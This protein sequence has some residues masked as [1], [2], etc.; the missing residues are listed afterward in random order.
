MLCYAVLCCAML[1]CV[2][3]CCTL[4]FE[5]R[6]ESYYWLLDVLDLYK[7][8]VWEY[9]RLNVEYNV[10][11]KRRLLRLVEEG[12]VQ[13][14]DDPRL[15]TLNGLRRR[16]YSP[17]AIRDFCF[18]ES[19][20]RI[21]TNHGLLFLEEIETLLDNN[22]VVLYGCYD[23]SSKQLRYS[24]GRIVY[25]PAQRK[26]QLLVFTSRG[27]VA[28][29]VK[30]SGPYGLDDVPDDNSRGR[31]VSLRVTPDH[32]MFAQLGYYDASGKL[33]ATK[34]HGPVTADKLVVPACRCPPVR[35]G[36]LDCKHRRAAMRLLA[37]AEAGYLPRVAVRREQVRA[38]LHLDDIQFIKFI[39]LL[40]FWLGDGFMTYKGK[41]GE[42]YNSVSFSQ[43]KK[44]DLDWLKK[45]FVKVGLQPSDWRTAKVGYQTRL[46]ITQPA[47]FAYFDG[48]FGRKYK[49]SRHFVNA[50][51]AGTSNSTPPSATR[52]SSVSSVCDLTSSCSTTFTFTPR[53]RSVSA[54]STE[55][56]DHATA[57]TIDAPA[58]CCL[59]CGGVEGLCGDRLSGVWHCAVC[60][61]DF[62]DAATEP[63]G[64][65]T[66]EGM[67]VEVMDDEDQPAIKVEMDIDEPAVKDE[68]DEDVPVT[69]HVDEPDEKADGSAGAPIKKDSSG[70]AVPPALDT[71]VP[72][73]VK[74]VKWLPDWLLAELSAAEM[75]KFIR[76]LWRAD[77]AWSKQDSVIYT[78]G[79]RFRDQLQQALLHCGYTPFATIMYGK[80]N[81]RGYKY[82]DWSVDPGVYPKWWVEQL[83]ETEQLNFTPIKST[84]EGWR[85]NWT[86][87]CDAT[88]R[89]AKGSCFPPMARQESI[90][91]SSYD[92]GRDGRLWCVTI[93]HPDHLIFAQRAHRNSA[94]V[95]IKQS[96]PIVVGNCNAIGI[97]RN[98]TMIPQAT[99]EYWLRNDLETKARRAMCVVDPVRVVLTNYPADQVEQLTAPNFPKA[100]QLG[101]HTVP[102]SR[103]L[104]IDRDDV[105]LHDEK[106]FF[107]LAVGKEAHLKYAYN[108]RCDKIDVAADD[109]THITQL[110]CTVDSSNSNKPKGKLH[111]V[112][113]PSPG[114]PPLT[115]TLR[116]Y[117]NLF[118]SKVSTAHYR[119]CAIA[120]LLALAYKPVFPSAAS[121]LIAPLRHC[122]LLCCCAVLCCAV[123][124][125]R[126]PWKSMIG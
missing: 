14:W 50:A 76:G 117:D 96:R 71:K 95:V 38:A 108:I 41:N 43:L 13:G 98:E 35:A 39:K 89:P 6:R 59:L 55:S 85:V 33:N 22:K 4:E 91:T 48:E 66:D 12:H 116:L 47:W 51:R 40:G 101:S 42:G 1:W 111:W 56:F 125:C 57:S 36:E 74:S 103:V 86:D 27:E 65:W 102:F 62:S 46:S 73:L 60:I 18:P 61:A 77:G 109:P 37:V 94:G 24:E 68:D 63:A 30:R 17:E 21:L 19:D 121:C 52:S 44:T 2:A 10:M 123:L 16:G 87:V 105:R 110:H 112:A 11:S 45:R 83:S 99:L 49:N 82:K 115:V 97:S 70:T 7:P 25:P 34:Q 113:E 81:I 126:I 122:A 58:P 107:G 54:S 92:E 64:E 90:S 88:N 31:H 84:T 8:K 28:R 72:E 106:S 29:W 32:V 93:D 100:P 124:A 5:V 67:E 15:L 120:I 69:F 26:Q 9:S 78:S 23:V 53:G 20:T 79:V 104:Y 75:R 118:N 114:Q 80:D 3:Q 119:H